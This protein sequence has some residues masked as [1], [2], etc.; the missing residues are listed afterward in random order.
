MVVH[1]LLDALSGILKRGL[2]LFRHYKIQERSC[3][4]WCNPY[5]I[6]LALQALIPVIECSYNNIRNE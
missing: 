6:L 1:M 3:Q 2:P 5:V 4:N